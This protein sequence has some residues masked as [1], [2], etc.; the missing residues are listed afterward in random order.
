MKYLTAL[1]AS[2]FIFLGVWFLSGLILAFILPLRWWKIEFGIG[3]AHGNIPSILAG[4]LGAV[5]ASH[6]FKASLS[7]KTGKLY[8]RKRTNG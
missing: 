1:L 6:T 8:R 3:L 7:A 4:I 5:A 2:I